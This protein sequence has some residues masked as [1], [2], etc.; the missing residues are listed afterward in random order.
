MPVRQLTQVEIEEIFSDGLILFGQHFVKSKTT[1]NEPINSSEY[2]VANF[3]DS[4][5]KEEIKSVARVTE[6]ISRRIGQE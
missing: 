6:L 3:L 2:E 1:L 4:V 5:S